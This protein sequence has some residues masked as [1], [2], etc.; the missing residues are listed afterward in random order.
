MGFWCPTELPWQPRR[1][2]RSVGCIIITDLYQ[3]F[4]LNFLHPSLFCK[5]WRRIKPRQSCWASYYPSLAI[6]SDI[7][8]WLTLPA[9][10]VC[11]PGKA[12]WRKR[13]QM[14]IDR[15]R[16][17]GTKPDHRGR[18]EYSTGY[19][20]SGEAAGR[21][22]AKV[23][24]GKESSRDAQ[25]QRAE[26]KPRNYSKVQKTRRQHKQ[27]TDIRWRHTVKER[28]DTGR[29]E[30]RSH[31]CDTLGRGREQHTGETKERK[32]LS[33]QDTKCCKEPLQLNGKQTGNSRNKIHRTESA[34]QIK[35]DQ[36]FV[37]RH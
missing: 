20:L 15:R 10:G 18:R 3:H 22:Q 1:L 6:S 5:G 33:S 11:L 23:K 34:F 14:E 17:F 12:G 9:L 7:N 4:P 13:E 25:I 28:T 16:G 35:R 8:E 31:R 2:I 27:W 32:W 36:K 30:L 37:S 21:K 29:V 26:A 24:T 19:L